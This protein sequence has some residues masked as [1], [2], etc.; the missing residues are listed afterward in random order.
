VAAVRGERAHVEFRG[1]TPQ[2]RD[3]IVKALGDK[4]VVQEGPWI[5]NLYVSINTKKPPFDNVD[6][7][8]ALNLAIDRYEGARALAAISIAQHVGGLMR[9][10][11]PFAMP[12]D[13]L[14]QIEGYGRDANAAKQQARQLLKE[15]GVQ[16]GFTF[17][18]RN[19][20]I[21]SPYEPVGLF[22]I[23][24]WR[25]VGLNANQQVLETTSYY[26][27]LRAGNYDVGID[28]IA[29]YIDEPDVQLGRFLSGDRSSLNYSKYEDRTLDELFDKQ[30]RESDPEKRKQLVWQFEKR[31]ADQAYVVNTHWWQRIVPHSAKMKGWKMAASHY[32][33]QDLTDVWLS[34]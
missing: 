20:D 33:N 11:G 18:F 2:A 21:P 22:L 31:V 14:A 27:D 30:S 5:S 17:S 10:K 1:F 19:R 16:D 12:D 32:I 13:Q 9:P 7:R 3:D 23:D 34:E 4:I 15:A 24:Q 6:V 25:K 26:N 28:F 8:R 29:D